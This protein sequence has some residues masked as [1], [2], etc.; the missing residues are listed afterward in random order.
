MK[1]SVLIMTYNEQKNI[2][3]CIQSVLGFSD[4][5]VVLDSFSSDDTVSISESLG[6]RVF[7]RKFDNYASQR[8]YGI[9]ELKFHND[10]L[11]LL[12]ADEALT[13]SLGLE[14]RALQ[15][16]SQNT[17]YRFRRKDF[18]CNKWIKHSSG[19]PTWFGRL[20]RI[21]H[22]SVERE[23]NEEYHTTGKVELL[24]K[25]INH[26]PF[27]K[28]VSFW[29]ERHNNY[30]TMEADNFLH[31]SDTKLV[32]AFS[33]DPATRRACIKSIVYRMPFRPFIVFFIFYIYKL[34]FL[35]GAPGL[36]FSLLKLFYELMIDLKVE[37]KKGT[38]L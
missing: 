9:N 34:G 4:D 25:H 18:F 13:E 17:L 3:N 22:V 23:I 8:N 12:D 35:D 1:F 14:I 32:D 33:S 38:S 5:V 21:G 31:K 7:S 24:D 11:L 16:E 19:Y 6:A 30:S 2:S 29:L 28:G 37:E 10:W 36:K 27:N 26:Y 15:P 20:V